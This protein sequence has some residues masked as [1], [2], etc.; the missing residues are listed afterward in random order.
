MTSTANQP[1]LA[2]IQLF[3]DGSKEEIDRSA[4]DGY[5]NTRSAG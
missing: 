2:A 1:F 3:V 4:T 5:Q